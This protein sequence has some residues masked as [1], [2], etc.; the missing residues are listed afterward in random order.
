MTKAEK[1]LIIRSHNVG[2]PDETARVLDIDFLHEHFKEISIIDHLTDGSAGIGVLRTHFVQNTR[3]LIILVIENQPPQDPILNILK[4]AKTDPSIPLIM[5][6]PEGASKVVT[7]LGA[8]APDVVLE[9][10]FDAAQL[11]AAITKVLA[12]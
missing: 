4:A 9:S 2:E 6:V 12:S 7:A 8:L 11:R 3:Y 1:L 10:P 5:M